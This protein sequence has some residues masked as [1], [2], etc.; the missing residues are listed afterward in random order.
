MRGRVP[1]RVRFRVTDRSQEAPGAEPTAAQWSLRKA[2]LRALGRV[3]VSISLWLP[4]P[5]NSKG[6]WS[7]RTQESTRAAAAKLG[8]RHGELPGSMPS[9]P[10]PLNNPRSVVLSDFGIGSPWERAVAMVRVRSS[11]V[12]KAGATPVL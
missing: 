3:P 2:D 12:A 5:H 10:A 6:P 4:K 11:D 9:D 7:G 1:V 8:K